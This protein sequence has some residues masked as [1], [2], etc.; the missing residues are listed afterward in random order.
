MIKMT[1]IISA[2]SILALVL[3]FSGRLITVDHVEA[4]DRNVESFSTLALWMA[5]ASGILMVVVAFWTFKL[6]IIAGIIPF[7]V[8]AGLIVYCSYLLW[9]KS[10]VGAL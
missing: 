2:L 10:L 3:M 8:G 9:C 6:H 4:N 7:G 1:I 5:V